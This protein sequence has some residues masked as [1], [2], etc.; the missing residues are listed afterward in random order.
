MQPKK[1]HF[2]LQLNSINQSDDFTILNCTF[3]VHDFERSW[4][5]QIVSK[6]VALSGAHTLKNKPIVAKYYSVENGNTSTDALGDHAQY[7]GVNRYG[8]KDVMTDTVPIGVITTEGYI[9]T[10]QENGKEKEVLAVD[11][12]LWRSR[13]S[14][15]CDLLLEWYQRGVRILSSVEYLYKNFSFRD[16]IEYIESPIF[17]DGHCVLNSEQRGDHDIVLPAYDSSHLLSFNDMKEF[18]RLV[19]QAFNQQSNKEGEKMEFFKKVCELS[20]EDVRSK[21][22][23]E[24][25]SKMTEDEYEHSWIVEVYDT[26]F[27]YHTWAD[28]GKYYQVNYSKTEDTVTV[29]F[30]TK[31][32]VMEERKWV[33]VTEVQALQTQLNE[34]NETVK[35]LKQ[36]FEAVQN[37]KDKLTKQ[38]N[39]SA[40]KLVSLNAQI[41]EL[42]PFKEKY[43]QEQFEKK[44]NEKIE[45]YNEKFMAVNA[46]DKFNTEEVQELIKKSLNDI[47]DEGK[48]AILQLNTMLVDLVQVQ[49][50]PNENLAVREFA[51]KRENLIPVANDFDS[52]YSL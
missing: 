28:G 20:H 19:A 43:E 9:M 22:Y 18:T 10:V 8:E 41:D 52:R 13:F 40:E 29:D 51:S 39:E 42:K 7:L 2:Q 30:D 11:A 33:Q 1:S 27:I 31:V 6:E 36:E 5:N 34:A 14:D 24:M 47:S 49:N 37:E 4:N 17:Y 15:A 21:L 12:V 45:Y 48:E 44:L 46:A 50:K 38:F 32:E 16:G 35:S 26:H 25:S 3:V 23:G